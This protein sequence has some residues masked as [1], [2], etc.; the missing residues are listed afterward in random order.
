MSD[1]T[2]QSNA[3]L[4]CRKIMSGKVSTATTDS[5]V[6]DAAVLMREGDIGILPIV[7]SGGKLLGLLTDR[8]IVVRAVA[9]G[10][11]ITSVKVG[12]IMSRELH[13]AQPDDFVFEVI[14]MMGEKQ[15]RRVPIVDAEGRLEGIISLA[16]IALE[17][18]DEREVA[19]ALEEISS[20]EAFWNKR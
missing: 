13:T 5:S 1:V 11:D 18:E 4:K 16:D 14:R 2:A 8:D 17:M 12:E 10:M 15:V 7:D 3:R 6:Q 19:E 20:G 9:A